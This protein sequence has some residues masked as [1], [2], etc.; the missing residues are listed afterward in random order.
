M[1][2]VGSANDM[3]AR[4]ET[5]RQAG[6]QSAA[7]IKQNDGVAE[8]VSQLDVSLDNSDFLRSIEMRETINCMIKHGFAHVRGSIWNS[9]QPFGA[10]EYTLFKANAP[11]VLDLC[12][13]CGRGGHYAREWG[14]SRTRS[15]GWPSAT[16]ARR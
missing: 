2:Y 16:L 3:D 6:D 11:E 12:H 10:R 14:G 4:I 9:C 13:R 8:I 1:F 15:P 5:H 7:W